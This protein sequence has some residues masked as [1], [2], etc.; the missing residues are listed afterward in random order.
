MRQKGGFFDVYVLTTRNIKPFSLKRKFFDVKNREM[1]NMFWKDCNQPSFY[2]H[3]CKPD[4]FLY[5]NS[6]N[7]IYPRVSNIVWKCLEQNEQK[8]DKIR[9]KLIENKKRY[10]SLSIPASILKSAALR[11]SEAYI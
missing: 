7:V 6:K 9:K 10:F 5:L 11:K 1:L 3:I 2:K 8:F 4:D